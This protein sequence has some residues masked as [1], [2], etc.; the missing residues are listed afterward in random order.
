MKEYKCNCEKYQARKETER[1]P[2][3]AY[4]LVKDK[5]TGKIKKV[6]F[7]EKLLSL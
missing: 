4:T 1:F 5:K 7:L 3:G 6:D 2:S